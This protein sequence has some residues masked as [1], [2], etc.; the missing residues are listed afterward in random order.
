[1]MPAKRVIILP[2][3]FI[4]SFLSFSVFGQAGSER[5]SSFGDNWQVNYNLGFTQFYGDASNTG[6]FKKLSGQIAFGTGFTV[7]KYF[8]PVFGVGF[9][10]LYTGLKSHKDIV[11]GVPANI[12]LTGSYLDAN[13]HIII[14]FNNLFWGTSNRKFSVYGT[15]GLGFSNWN[16]QLSDLN[17]GRILNTGDLVNGITYGNKGLV[18]P[19]GIGVNYM[20]NPNWALNF[21]MNLRTVF[22]DDVDVWRDGFKYDQPL[23]TSLGVSYFINWKKHVK[24]DKRPK[25]RPVSTTKPAEPLQGVPIYDYSIRNIKQN[26]GGGSVS[27]GGDPGIILITPPADNHVVYRVQILAK[28]QNLPTV[29]ELKSRYG[30]QQNIYENVYNGIHR[31][32]VGAFN[33]YNEAM[34]LSRQLQN[35]GIS[36][37]FV[38]AYRDNQRITITADMKK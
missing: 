19:F 33:T 25:G 23:Y 7:R 22:N 24:K 30:I 35:S 12:D 32:S 31:Y 21:D 27:T 18:V 28:R 10:F 29:N 3:I 37:A 17:S 8:N 38:V 9:N 2:A 15:L 34:Q 14:N 20:L 36:D 11:Q 5:N 1:M 16:S 6:Y 13:L 26:S 4:L